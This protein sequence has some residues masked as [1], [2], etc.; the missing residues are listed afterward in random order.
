MLHDL[1][2][3]STWVDKAYAAEVNYQKTLN[4]LRCLVAGTIRLEQI[5]VLDNAWEVHDLAAPQPKAEEPPPSNVDDVDGWLTVEEGSCLARRAVIKR[6]L[7]L[8]SYCGKSTI[9]MARVAK[10]VTCVDTFDGRAC[11]VRERET[12][13]DF[14][15]NIRR[16]GVVE[17]IDVRQGRNEDIVPTLPDASFDF[18]F[19]DASHDFFSVKNDIALALPKLTPGGLIAFHDYERD[20]N[21]QIKPAVDEMLLAPGGEIIERV[22]TIAVIKPAAVSNGV[23]MGG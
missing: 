2:L 22:G 4:I 11:G 20:T 7:E 1:K 16:Y 13:K 6:V 15:A 18:I 23:P 21:P 5:K 14:V 19:I 3:M 17:K 9:W 10:S 8:G 12:F